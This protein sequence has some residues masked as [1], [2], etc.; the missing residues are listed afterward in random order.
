REVIKAHNTILPSSYERLS[1]VKRAVGIRVVK[2]GDADLCFASRR[3]R[4]AGGDVGDAG[5]GGLHFEVVGLGAVIVEGRDGAH[6]DFVFATGV[7][8]VVVAT[9]GVD[10]VGRASTRAVC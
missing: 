3:W 10:T 5:G 6:S 7:G 1:S 9:G 4:G 2:F 8:G